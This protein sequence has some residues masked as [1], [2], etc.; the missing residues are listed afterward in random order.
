MSNSKTVLIE[1]IKNFRFLQIAYHLGLLFIGI[2]LSYLYT[3]F[4]KLP[5]LP[6]SLILMLAVITAW[7]STVFFNDIADIKIDKISNPSRPLQRKIIDK[8]QSLSI[9]IVSLALS[10]LLAQFISKTLLIILILYHIISWIYSM[11]PLRLKKIPI[12]ATF[13]ASIASILIILIGFLSTSIGFKNL[14]YF[15]YT[16]ALTLLIGY[17]L[18]L[19]IKDLKDYEGDKYDGIKTIPVLFGIKTSRKIIGFNLFI[20]FIISAVLLNFLYLIVPA[21]LFG[22]ISLIILTIQKND[23]HLIKIPKLLPII[24][25]I[26]FMYACIVTYVLYKNIF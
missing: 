13:L 20:S 14:Q 9:G 10:L 2:G 1:I 12:L 17:T 22:S 11:K 5:S 15:P 24:F 25:S 23:S 6:S 3:P 16:I 26:V 7:I 19:P 8:N 21:I 4:H 18:S